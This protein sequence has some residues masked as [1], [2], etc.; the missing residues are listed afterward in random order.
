MSSVAFRLS[1]A[2]A[3]ATGLTSG[4]VSTGLPPAERARIK[5]AVVVANLDEKLTYRLVGTTAFTNARYQRPD[6]AGG[7]NGRLESLAAKALSAE[8]I[9]VVEGAQV[10]GAFA[11]IETANNYWTGRDTTEIKPA[12]AELSTKVQADTLLLLTT[13]GM[14]DPFLGTNQYFEGYGLYHRA[15]FG[16]KQSMAYMV[17]AGSLYDVAT[18]RL[19]MRRSA[20]G[21]SPL[22]EFAWK[23]E[24][25]EVTPE[26]HA[27]LMKGLEEAAAGAIYELMDDFGLGRK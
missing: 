18:G 26:E 22:G 23:K 11:G 13:V 21:S 20:S 10:R 9:Q 24:E 14:Q 1:L 16:T 17:V 4:C 27:R 2:L 3:L 19:I 12:L 8:G 6:E 25:A 5:T 7:R 15:F